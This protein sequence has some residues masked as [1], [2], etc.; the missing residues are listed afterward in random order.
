[1]KTVQ[2]SSSIHSWTTSLQIINRANIVQCN[3]DVANFSP[4]TWEVFAVFRIHS[5]QAWFLRIN[6]WQQLLV[7][8]K[9]TNLNL[10]LIPM[11]NRSGPYY[12]G[13]DPGPNRH[14]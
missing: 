3:N 14:L 12:A 5:R 13:S 9:S 2:W 10:G 7:V 8:S 6:D 11:E 1:M 4:H